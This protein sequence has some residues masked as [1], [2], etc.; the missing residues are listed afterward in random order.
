MENRV[1]IVDDEKEIRQFLTAAPKTIG[2]YRVEQAEGGED[3]LWRIR[4]EEF[5]LVLTTYPD[6]GPSKRELFRKA[7]ER[8]RR[9]K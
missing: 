1:L 3:A 2:P 5:E 7:K 4:N 8:L 9:S 6:E